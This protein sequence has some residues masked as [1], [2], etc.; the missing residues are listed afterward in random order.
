[1]AH[2]KV[3][4][5]QIEGIVSLENGGTNNATFSASQILAIDSSTSSI[6]SSGYKFN[7]SGTSS[8][9]IWS[10]DKIISY[11]ATPS[12]NYIDFATG[13]NVIE[14]A[15]RLYFNYNSNSLAYNPITPNND[16]VIDIGQDS[17]TQIYNSTGATLSI[18]Q[19]VHISG[20]TSNSFP[21][22][23]LSDASEI[24]DRFQCDGI[25]THVISNNSIGFITTM[26]IVNGFDLSSFQIGEEVS[27]SDIVPGGLIS[28]NQ[29]A[30]T[31]RI[32]TI[33]TVLSNVSSGSIYVNLRNEFKTTSLPIKLSNILTGNLASNGIFQFSG[34][35]FS[36][37]TFSVGPAKGW[38]VD[39]S[40]NP[41]NPIITYV[42]YPGQTGLTTSYLTTDYATYLMITTASSLLMQPTFPTD[43]QRRQNI[44]LGKLG[45]GTKTNLLNAFNEPDLDYSPLSQLR[46]MF[47]PIKIINDGVITSPNGSNLSFNTSAGKLWG[48]GIGFVENT[49]TP[50]SFI[51]NAQ[52]P[53][54]FQYRGM[55][56]GTGSDITSIDPTVYD[57]NGIIT[58]IGAPTKQST[59][60]R[61]Y[62][63]QNGKIRVQYGQKIY[64]DLTTAVSNA[65]SELFN[66]FISF[67]DNAIL[68]GILS[69]VSNA[70][71]L[72]NTSQALFLSVSK[73]GEIGGGTLG[74]ST[75]TLQQAYNNSSTPEI[76]INSTLDGLSISN[77]TGNP[78]SSTHLIEGINA[79]GSV[80]S[81]IMADGTISGKY[82]NIAY[83]GFTNSIVTQTLT[84][85]NIQTFQNRTGIV[86]HLDQITGAISGV[87]SLNGITQSTQYFTSSNDSN[88]TL[89]IISSGSTHSYNVGWNGV[90]SLDRGGLNNTTFTQSQ[91]LITSTNSVISSGYVFNDSG[92]SSTDILSAENIIQKIELVNKYILKTN[93]LRI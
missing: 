68:I 93:S 45:H 3:N 55:S 75:T 16:L 11:S 20:A 65:Q 60:Q 71:D 83:N 40:T 29:L 73:F 18:G 52:S 54:T 92:T 34:F 81:F 37:N 32:T 25:V 13:S 50:S 14:K 41:T 69:L 6:I 87:T 2:G 5:K 8:T 26:G 43:V 48:L 67:K 44:Y 89:N 78:D 17:Y 63:L 62:M 12:V 39:N 49:L 84:G 80:T 23:V 53:T 90:L 31:S 35:T 28:T 7:D 1:M 9:D 56:G 59:N 82:Y 42:D 33:G 70:S 46:D 24:T 21:Y 4:A 91:I 72:S 19:A 61:I 76:I 38:I 27:I 57:N 51:V 10:S 74:L 66:K 64:A 36:G 58:P 88:V 85:S 15:G 47:T 22:V 86:A 77:G 30:L 79:T